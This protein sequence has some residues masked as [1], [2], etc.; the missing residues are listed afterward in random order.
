MKDKEDNQISCTFVV[1][2]SS[3]NVSASWAASELDVTPNHKSNEEIV[4]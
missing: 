1:H 4:R 2:L 3:A